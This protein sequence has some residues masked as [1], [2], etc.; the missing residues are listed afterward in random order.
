MPSQ[1]KPSEACAVGKIR[2]H[3]A[4]SGQSRNMAREIAQ[5]QK[6]HGIIEGHEP[7]RRRCGRRENPA[8][9]V[10]GDGYDLPT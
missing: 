5:K 10:R 7:I 8:S 4:L 2:R 3:G 9:V 6:E 1:P